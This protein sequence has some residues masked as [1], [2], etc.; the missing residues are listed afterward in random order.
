MY[1]V[2]SEDGGYYE[3]AEV[4]LDMQDEV[5]DLILRSGGRAAE[6]TFAR[7]VLQGWPQALT[8]DIRA[9]VRGLC[10]QQAHRR[11]QSPAQDAAHAC[12]ARALGGRAKHTELAPL[13]DVA[14]RVLTAHITTAATERDWSMWGRVY[15]STRNALGQERAK[16]LI[17]VC[18]ES[19]TQ[20]LSKEREFE[21]TLQII[22]CEP[23]DD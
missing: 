16:K 21:V 13:L 7:L 20:K 22:D 2:L 6:D 18:S 8:R 10:R 9:I 23:E 14:R 1:A 19:K 11:R 3:V 12:A 5:K 17:A 15:N 4:A